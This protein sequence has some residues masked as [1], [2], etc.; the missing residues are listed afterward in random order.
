MD[1][2]VMRQH[3]GLYVNEFSTDLGLIGKKA[4]RKMFEYAKDAGIVKKIPGEIFISD[5][6]E[7]QSIK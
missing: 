6:L 1:D 4:V 2:A 7:E 3:I 5:W